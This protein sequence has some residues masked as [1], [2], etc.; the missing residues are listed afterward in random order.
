MNDLRFSHIE[1]RLERL[2]EGSFAQIFHRSIT[3]HDMV[4]QLA[5]ALENNLRFSNDS[6]PRPIGP[7]YYEVN[8]QTELFQQLLENEPILESQLGQSLIDLAMLLGYRLLD[9]PHV[10][11]RPD[12]TLRANDLIVTAKHLSSPRT[13]T[14]AMSR[15]ELPQESPAPKNPQLLINGTQTIDLK[16]PLIN[17]GRGRDN[18]IV[19]E[20]PYASRH[21]VQLRLRY[22]AYTLFD[23]NSQA[24]VL[25]N[26]VPAREHRLQSGD[27]FRI[28]KTRLIYLEDEDGMTDAQD[29]YF[30]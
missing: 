18:H 22:G 4:M 5:R 27:V 20:D 29:A 13:H 24:G 7:D 1:N 30:D 10:K 25:V 11:I 12:D 6:D 28:G 9:V 23:T 2:I 3:A 19:L 16:D 14:A 21:H 15:I 26:D 8:I 17:I